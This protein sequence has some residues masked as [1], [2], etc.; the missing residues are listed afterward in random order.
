VLLPDFEDAASLGQV[1]SRGQPQVSLS[2]P[3]VHLTSR[4]A[5]WFKKFTETRTRSR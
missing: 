1:L 4:Y 5:V 2:S 3:L